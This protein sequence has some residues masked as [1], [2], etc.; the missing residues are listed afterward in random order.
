MKRKLAYIAIIDDI[1][2]IKDA[3]RIELASINGWNV[4]VGKNEFRVGEKVIFCEI[5]SFLPVEPDF[6][7]LRKSSYK[8]LPSGQDGFRLRTVKMKGVVSQGLVLPLSS[9][10][11]RYYFG[12]FTIGTDVS[13]VLGITKYEKPIPVTM[14][15]KVKSSFPHFIPRTDEERIQNVRLDQLSNPRMYYI[16]EKLDGTS[17]TAY[18]FNGEFGVCSRNLELKIDDDN[19]Y[20]GVAAEY[21]LKTKLF[22]LNLAIQGEILGPGIQGNKYKISKPILYVFGIYDIDAKTYLDFETVKM[23]CKLNKLN[24]VPFIDKKIIAVMDRQGI[25]EI[26]S[27]ADGYSV[28]NDKTKREGLVY[29]SFTEEGTFSFKVISNTFLLDEKDEE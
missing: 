28:L 20:V 11:M 15:G 23:F 8:M 3:D 22:D 16:T 26:L 29:K 25:N 24:T 12:D 19:V 14:A 17:F 2:P 18:N 9:L 27:G 4:I 6:E 5:D 13:E 10:H 7:F 1:N 21:D